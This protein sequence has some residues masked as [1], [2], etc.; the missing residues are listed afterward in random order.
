MPPT[1][2]SV[3]EI[4]VLWRM[5]STELQERPSFKPFQNLEVDNRSASPPLSGSA[6]RVRRSALASV[7]SFL[8]SKRRRPDE[9]DVDKL[10]QGY[11][12]NL[13]V[14]RQI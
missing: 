12:S 11:I 6:S 3:Y 13:R 4:S 14:L 2:A 5:L 8:S 7:V 10:T 1:N 9:M